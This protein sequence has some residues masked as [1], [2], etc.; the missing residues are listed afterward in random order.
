M[1]KAEIKEELESLDSGIVE[2]VIE[3]CK[4]LYCDGIPLYKWDYDS[5]MERFDKA[6]RDWEG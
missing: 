4:E 1:S 2:V 5:A 3:C 6:T